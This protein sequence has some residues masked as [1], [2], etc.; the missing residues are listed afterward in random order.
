MSIVYDSE[1]APKQTKPIWILTVLDSGDEIILGA[2]E[3]DSEAIAARDSFQ[4]KESMGRRF[5]V[6]CTSLVGH[7]V[8]R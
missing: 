5:Y 6:V 7:A 1:V 3:C 4:E 2:Y 8:K